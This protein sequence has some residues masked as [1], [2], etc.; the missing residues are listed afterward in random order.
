[1]SKEIKVIEQQ[2]ITRDYGFTGVR[3]VIEHPDHGRLLIEDGYGGENTLMGG[4][5]RFIHGIVIR[6][7]PGD[8]LAA[9][10]AGSWNDCTNTLSAVLSGYDDERPI[11]PWH[12]NQ[13]DLIARKAGL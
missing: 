4:A 9:M 2:F 3:A 11:L 12:G 13:I 5:V 10:K 1:M 7:K 8:N 6:L